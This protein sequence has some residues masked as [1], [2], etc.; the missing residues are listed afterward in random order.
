MLQRQE[1]APQV[2]H[3]AAEQAAKPPEQVSERSHLVNDLHFDSPTASNS[4]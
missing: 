4:P 1:I 2:I 3:L